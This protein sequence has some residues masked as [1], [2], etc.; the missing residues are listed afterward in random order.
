MFFILDLIVRSGYWPNH[1]QEKKNKKQTMNNAPPVLFIP[2]NYIT[3]PPQYIQY[4]HPACTCHVHILKCLIDHIS[5]LVYV[6]GCNMY[7][8]YLCLL[9]T[10]LEILFHCC[11]VPSASYF[12]PAYIFHHAFLCRTCPVVDLHG[13]QLC[14]FIYTVLGWTWND[15]HYK[16]VD[17]WLV[18]PIGAC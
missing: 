11:L 6:S 18:T 14:L 15:I 8:A 13:L 2:D 1:W 7:Y 16:L 10:L 17:T 5:Q 12:S 3:L 4:E 9:L